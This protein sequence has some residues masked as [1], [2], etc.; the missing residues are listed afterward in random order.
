MINHCLLLLL[1]KLMQ[2]LW[3]I[4]F[5]ADLCVH[6]VGSSRFIVGFILEQT[7]VA[8]VVESASHK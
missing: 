6:D 8:K 3:T 4:G 7:E 5:N 1:V 2:K